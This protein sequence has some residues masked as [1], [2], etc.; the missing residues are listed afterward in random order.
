MNAMVPSNV[1][2]ARVRPSGEK[3]T[4]RYPAGL[5]NQTTSDCL[6]RSQTLRTEGRLS[7]PCWPIARRLPSGEKARLQIRPR[8]RAGCAGARAT[9][10][11]GL[12]TNRLFQL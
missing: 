3:A 5:V 11:R 6:A 7:M 8:A 2:A 1:P 12:L 4:L 9:Q 10:F